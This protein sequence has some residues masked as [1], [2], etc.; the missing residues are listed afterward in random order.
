[1]SN[2]LSAIASIAGLIDIAAE[3]SSQ[4]LQLIHD[5][6][7]AP[8]QIHFLSQEINIS[9]Q[10]AHQLIELRDLLANH[11]VNQLLSYDTA[12][13]VQLNRA[14]PVW[15]ELEEILGSVKS[16]DSKLCK[17]KQMRK[18]SRV[19]SLQGKL[20]EIR[21]SNLE[22]LGM[23]NA[24]QILH[25]RSAITTYHNDT[26][27]MYETTAISLA[28]I[29]RTLKNL[30][31]GSSIFNTP[32]LTGISHPRLGWAGSLG[33]Q[34]PFHEGKALPEDGTLKALSGSG[35][36]YQR[37]RTNECDSQE[38][39]PWPLY[40][41]YRASECHTHK[42]RHR[43]RIAPFHSAFGT[44]V[45]VYSGWTF[46][47]Q[48]CYISSCLRSNVSAVEVKYSLPRW[49]LNVTI[50]ATFRISYGLPT[51]GLAVQRIIPHDT[52]SRFQSIIGFSKLGNCDAIRSLLGRRPDAV[53]DIAEHTRAT[54][55]DSAL[56]YHQIDACRLLLQAGADPLAEDSLGIPVIAY[57]ALYRHHRNKTLQLEFEELLPLSS[58]Y[59]EYEFSHLHKIVLGVRPLDLRSQLSDV[60]C[61]AQLNQEEKLGYTP[62]HWASSQGDA[63]AVRLLLEAGAGVDKVNANGETPLH[64]ACRSGSRTCAEAL[65]LADA[66]LHKRL[67]NGYQPVHVAA[68]AMD[69]VEMLDCLLSHRV[70]LNDTENFYRTTPLALTTLY[71]RVDNCEFLLD[72]GA[73]IDYPDWEGDTPMFEGIKSVH[74]A[75]CLSLFLSRGC[76]YLHTNFQGQ[77]LLHKVAFLGNAEQFDVLAAADLKGLMPH[78][79]DIHNMSAQQ[80]LNGRAGISRDHKEAFGKLIARLEGS[81]DEERGYDSDEYD[82]FVDAL[83]F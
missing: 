54:A 7:D 43:V 56:R 52:Y 71:D 65:I 19:V 61:H 40:Q 23:Y 8:K 69:G 49:S 68:M 51:A 48:N 24:S 26:I 11:N 62:L 77:N 53:F 50:L 72:H 1:M 16:S 64:S 10:I 81:N 38:G 20:R 83:E 6:K 36:V 37:S 17:A 55:L 66:D 32:A 2:P 45:L 42:R 67:P 57:V 31:S 21:F 4:V 47:A 74:G 28:D 13:S 18:G 59:E 35:R 15:A 76:N 70:S 63:L 3:T 44:F 60:T 80:Y 73:P 75:K 58:F 12:L 5:W 9:R 33:E 34:E 39:D 79:R 30:E 14:K 25:I 29:L 78:A 46:A 82:V 27:A 22:I 41:P